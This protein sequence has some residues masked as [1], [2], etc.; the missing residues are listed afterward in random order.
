VTAYIISAL[1]DTTDE[2]VAEVLPALDLI[3]LDEEG[4]E[5]CDKPVGSI[6]R[7]LSLHQVSGRSVT[8]VKTE[9]AFL[10]A[11]GNHL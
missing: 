10:E 6:E 9:D 1:E 11:D 5:E 4:K 7:F 3:W 2:M 8:V